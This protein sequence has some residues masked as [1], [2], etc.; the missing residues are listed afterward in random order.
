M[1]PTLDQY[2]RGARAAGKSDAEIRQGLLDQGWP[3][4]LIDAALSGQTPVVE[5]SV[6]GGTLKPFGALFKES[7]GSYGYLMGI[8]WPVLALFFTANI[9][10][11]LLKLGGIEASAAVAAVLGIAAFA[12]SLLLPIAEILALGEQESAE[13]STLVA[14]LRAASRKFFGFFWV[15][16]LKGLVTLGAAAA[17]IVPGFILGVQTIFV[18]YTYVLENR[19]GLASIESSR[20][21]VRGL[22]W[23]VF[24]RIFIFG[25]I[26][27]GIF[28]IAG[29]IASAVSV[30]AILE[31]VRSGVD[32]DRVPLTPAQEF[33]VAAV[34]NLPNVLL[35]PLFAAFP[36]WL[37]R[38]LR[39]LRGVAAAGE[40]RTDTKAF[41]GLGIVAA[42]VIVVFFV[43]AAAWFIA[44]VTGTNPA[45]WASRLRALRGRAD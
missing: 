33:L 4:H 14:L 2:I 37:Y 44:S 16:L 11:P 7:L 13:R 8:F 1:D 41:L 15:N 9:V 36:F 21:M 10:E 3:E 6:A 28:L 24:W 20:N 12:L 34:S 22:G 40:V 19:R 38:D 23:T 17:F 45:D 31:G 32:P 18:P 26:V 35:F 42:A 43:V 29:I 5:A 27:A 25:L 39:R 30:P